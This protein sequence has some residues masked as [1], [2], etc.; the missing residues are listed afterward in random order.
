VEVRPAGE[1]PFRVEARCRFSTI[2]GREV[3]Q[4]TA[5][6]AEHP[7]CQ[8]CAHLLPCEPAMREDY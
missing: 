1:A 7:Q 2:P 8:Y 6:V 3:D 5:S 4:S